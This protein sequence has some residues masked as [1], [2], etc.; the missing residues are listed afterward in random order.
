MVDPKIPMELKKLFVRPLLNEILKM[1]VM[2]RIDVP[3]IQIQSVDSNEDVR[4]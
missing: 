2:M 1:S 3:K 4:I